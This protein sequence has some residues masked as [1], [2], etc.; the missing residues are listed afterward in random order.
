LNFNFPISNSKKNK[1]R[2]LSSQDAF[3]TK[4]K[5][6]S[7]NLII[8]SNSNNT[9]NKNNLNNNKYTNKNFYEENAKKQKANLASN[10]V[11]T[12]DQ[13]NKKNKKTAN[14]K[15]LKTRKISVD[16]LFAKKENIQNKANEKEDKIEERRIIKKNKNSSEIGG[17][18]NMYFYN[19]HEKEKN[20]YY[21]EQ[22][23]YN[24]LDYPSKS[25]YF[26]SNRYFRRSSSLGQKNFKNFQ[27]YGYKT[28]KAN[29]KNFHNFKFSQSFNY[30]SN[31]SLNK[32]SD[33]Y[34]KFQNRKDSEFPLRSNH[35]SQNLA[36]NVNLN[37]HS[38]EKRLKSNSFN[39]KNNYLFKKSNNDFEDNISSTK[40]KFFNNKF[41]KVENS[42]GEKQ[43]QKNLNIFNL[44][45]EMSSNKSKKNKWFIRSQNQVNYGPF[46]N[47]EIYNYLKTTMTTNP[48]SELL[49]N[50]IIIDSEVDIY[51]KP[52]SAL[53]VIQQDI[54]NISLPKNPQDEL[55]K[56][57]IK[58][59]NDES[60]SQSKS[61]KLDKTK[62]NDDEIDSLQKNSKFILE[63]NKNTE[64]QEED[65]DSKLLSEN[66]NNSHKPA[67]GE[68]VS[69]DDLYNFIYHHQKKLHSSEID[70]SNPNT[71]TNLREIGVVSN[72]PEYNE[73]LK[74]NDYVAKDDLHFNPQKRN[75]PIPYKENKIMN[76]YDH[77]YFNNATANLTI[78]PKRINSFSYA[79]SINLESNKILL[80]KNFNKF[81]FKRN[82]GKNKESKNVN[83]VS[84]E[85][86]DSKNLE[87]E[88]KRPN[89]ITAIIKP[90]SIEDIFSSDKK[91]SEINIPNPEILKEIKDFLF[92]EKYEFKAH[93]EKEVN[94][95]Q[96]L[97]NLM[98]MG[99]TPKIEFRKQSVDTMQKSSSESLDSQIKHFLGKKVDGS[100][101]RNLNKAASNIFSNKFDIPLNKI[102]FQ[103]NF[104]HSTATTNASKSSPFSHKDS[105]E[106][107][108]SPHPSPILDNE[109]RENTKNDSAK[110]EDPK[111]RKIDIDCLFSNK[112]IKNIENSIISNKENIDENLKKENEVKKD[113]ETKPS[114][115]IKNIPI[116]DLFS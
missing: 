90:V 76:L 103:R 55:D 4:R 111:R 41:D 45:D 78:F 26:H 33:D 105:E 69:P 64:K 11:S 7:E 48:N 52:D 47:E 10:P 29:P 44:W 36:A 38:F 101:A 63:E 116:Q 77:D 46:S 51:F 93:N 9:D 6:P 67:E 112:D 54:K 113:L 115:N 14:N 110:K 91:P 83:Q 61:K 27:N 92:D 1:N 73:I 18:C 17:I 96:N 50:S 57:L 22:A 12:E 39:N 56:I 98:D 30:Y 104:S 79:N 40:N 21:F 16:E 28:H 75:L 5:L 81:D 49:K 62:Q 43:E 37:S 88:N 13:Q 80:N 60:K 25:N 85:L 66:Q 106:S 23:N 53:E 24:R 99:F 70:E 3:Y 34:F 19:K 65:Q 72:K 94:E 107:I 20:N 15:I 108:L 71:N 32:K 89:V 100:I 59:N 74:K 114:L 82:I 31:N 109:S 102:C 87:K 97:K 68:F 35:C 95:N 42:L 8:N 2:K 58:V 84:S 86:S